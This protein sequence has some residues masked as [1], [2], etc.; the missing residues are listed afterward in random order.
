MTRRRQPGAPE[1]RCGEVDAS[2]DGQGLRSPSGSRPGT[3]ATSTNGAL[4]TGRPGGAPMS[5]GDRHA[6][7][8]RSNERCATRLRQRRWRGT[9]RAFPHGARRF[10]SADEVLDGLQQRTD[11]SGDADKRPACR[12]RRWL[13]RRPRSALTRASDFL[14]RRAEPMERPNDRRLR[15]HDRLQHSLH[16]NSFP[17]LGKIDTQ[18][19]RRICLPG[20]GEATHDPHQPDGNH[21]SARDWHVESPQ[22][23]GNVFVLS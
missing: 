10:C 2:D 19:H 20:A 6:V 5:V 16:E 15:R 13:A 9:C 8:Q 22:K 12:R 21:I 14:F 7:D 18:F 4:L 3:P 1:W 17:C 11:R 23:C